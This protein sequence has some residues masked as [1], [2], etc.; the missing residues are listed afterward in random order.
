M[1]REV[2]LNISKYNYI[3]N[4]K[5]DYDDDCLMVYGTT[6]F[7]LV[8]EEVCKVVMQND[9][10]NTLHTIVSKHNLGEL[11]SSYEPFKNDTLISIINKPQWIS[12]SDVG[13][14]INMNKKRIR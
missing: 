9:L 2:H 4:K 3:S 14:K 12:Y 7:N 11:H 1:D 6:S 8:W 13:E 10:K 5:S